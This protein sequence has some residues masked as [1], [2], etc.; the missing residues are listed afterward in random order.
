[1]P[2]LPPKPRTHFA[3]VHKN[4]YPGQHNPPVY[5][6]HCRQLL[7]YCNFYTRYTP[8]TCAPSTHREATHR[9]TAI[10]GG[11]TKAIVTAAAITAVFAAKFQK[12]AKIPSSQ[13]RSP[14]TLGQCTT[15]TIT[16]A[17]VSSFQEHTTCL[18]QEHTD[19]PYQ[20]ASGFPKEVGLLSHPTPNKVPLGKRSF[21]FL[22]THPVSRTH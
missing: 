11:N 16:P 15:T 2:P 7:L 18:P 3:S 12:G 21:I 8:K 10:M 20:H 9:E 14:T 19:A 22:L 13:E 17:A 6:Y 4:N 1:M 5:F